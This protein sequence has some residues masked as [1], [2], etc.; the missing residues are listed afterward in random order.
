MPTAGDTQIRFGRSY[1][2]IDPSTSS[3]LLREAPSATVGT[4]RLSLDDEYIDDGG[5]GDDGPD[6]A[7]T[8]TAQ[9]KAGEGIVL[10]G[11]LLY[12]DS[13]GR[14]GRAIA[15]DLAKS[16][17]VGVALEEKSEGDTITYGSNLVIDLFNT[18]SIIEN[19]LGGLLAAG[20]HYYLSS[21]EA[22]KWTTTPDTITE[23][24]FV[25]QCG[26]AIGT[27]KMMIDILDRTEV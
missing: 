11:T 22:G 3:L 4:W 5:G 9:V 27:N 8:A 19:D 12:A 23:G 1:I 10:T 16:V 7:A 21:N 26:T 17:V 18:A 13:S 2:F 20:F 14:V 15:N 6:G 25:V 24:S